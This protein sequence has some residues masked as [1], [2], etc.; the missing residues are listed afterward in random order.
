VDSQLK[1]IFL[2]DFVNVRDRALQIHGGDDL[3]LKKFSIVET[4]GGI[5]QT[6]IL[7]RHS[8]WFGLKTA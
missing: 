3:N 4:R 6:L 5:F 8:I 1:T 7:E 2:E